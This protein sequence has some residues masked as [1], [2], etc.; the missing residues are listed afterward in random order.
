MQN[1]IRGSDVSLPKIDE[2]AKIHE[3]IYYLKKLF[4]NPVAKNLISKISTPKRL[5][6]IL[7]IY[8]G[9]DEPSGIKEKIYAKGITELIAKAAEKF[10]IDENLL[11]EGLKDPYYR[12]GVANVVAG[13]AKYGI[14]VPQ[15]LYAPF[16][17]VWNFTRKCNLR[18]KHCYANA[19]KTEYELSLAEK[20]KLVKQLD[21]AGVVAISFS[22]GEPLLHRD[23]WKVAEFASNLGFHVSIATNGTLITP[24]VAERLKK[25]GVCYVEVSLDAAS[26][27]THDNFR[28]IEGAFDRA[29][30]GIKNC[31]RVG[32]QTCIATTATKLNISEIPE[33][34]SLAEDLG[35]YRLV[36]FNFIPTGRGKEIT[37]LDLSVEERKWLLEFLYDALQKSHLQVLSTSPLFAVVAVEKVLQRRG[38]KITPTHFADVCMPSDSALV[39]SDF[40]GGCGAGRLYCGI[41]PN[42]DVTPCVFIPLIVGNYREGFLKIWQEN[43]VLESLRDRDSLDYAC[44]DC[45]FRYICGGC[46]A[47]AY[48]YFG[49]LKGMDPGCFIGSADV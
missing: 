37:K 9:I 1:H 19:G 26:P 30:D 21:D 13:I 6:K 49:D 8:C 41:Q 38:E 31:V 10:D 29:L 40:L 47:R 42:G 24:E 3:V 2:T 35:V 20:L 33:I 14:T 27:K 36:V 23:F 16:L 22:G 44:K 11:R 48:G 46:R 43:S 28:G 34:I 5:E 32:I 12:R 18:C 39:L 15:K 17:V 25:V 45:N 4:E 7:S